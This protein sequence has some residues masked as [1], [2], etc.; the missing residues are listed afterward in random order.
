M[1]WH[2]QLVGE[3]AEAGGRGDRAWGG[4]A[5]EQGSGQAELHHVLPPH[6]QPRPQELQRMGRRMPEWDLTGDVGAVS[7]LWAVAVKPRGHVATW[8]TKVCVPVPWSPPP[9][10]TG[11]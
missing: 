10:H 4:G 1:S 6:P 3:P 11:P 5:N 8:R 9:S 2:G 7:E